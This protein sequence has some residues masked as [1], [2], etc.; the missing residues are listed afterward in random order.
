M[1][2]RCDSGLCDRL[3]V[4]CSYYYYAKSINK[5]LQ[6]DWR[7]NK[8]CNGHFLDVFEK[9]E[10][11]DFLNTEDGKYFYAGNTP[12]IN[13]FPT[14]FFIFNILKPKEKIKEKINENLKKLGKN[15]LSLHVRRTDQLL[16]REPHQ[17]TQYEDFFEFIKKNNDKKVFLATDNRV[18][19]NI[20][21]SY[22]KDKIY[23]TEEIVP[24]Q[25]LRQTSLE[26]AVVDLFTC[27][28]SKS[29]MGTDCSGYTWFIECYR[30]FYKQKIF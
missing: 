2:V 10:G 28:E 19:Q 11:I 14:K 21:L 17:I 25:E 18:S 29:F 12:N 3:R 6:F 23:F 24:S 4:M 7:M 1:I 30:K 8:F 22:F 13:F 15:F 27:V 26:T 20:F 5:Q 16:L 9:I